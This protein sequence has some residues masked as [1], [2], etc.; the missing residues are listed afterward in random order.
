MKMLH[1][2]I[3][4]TKDYK[5]KL[6][7]YNSIYDITVLIAN[8][9]VFFKYLY[10]NIIPAS[11]E[12]VSVS[13]LFKNYILIS[14]DEFRIMTEWKC[15]CVCECRIFRGDEVKRK[16]EGCSSEKTPLG[17]KSPMLQP[18]FYRIYMKKEVD[19]ESAAC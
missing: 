5:V 9:Y 6:S 16:L 18:H 12:S 10:D 17:V 19:R 14:V 11:S 1:A 2:A 7:P 8:E 4:I 15:V 13:L 3:T